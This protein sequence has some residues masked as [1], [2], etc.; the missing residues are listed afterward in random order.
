MSEQYPEIIEAWVVG[1]PGETVAAHPT[2]KAGH[3][4]GPLG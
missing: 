2:E 4:I 3:W 1:K